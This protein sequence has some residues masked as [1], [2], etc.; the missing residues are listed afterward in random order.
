MTV[1]R[2]PVRSSCTDNAEG[3]WRSGRLEFRTSVG[4]RLERE[5][6][7]RRRHVAVSLG[8]MPHVGQATIEVIADRRDGAS[9]IR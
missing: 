4:L 7:A 9:A 6:E 3:G 1:S 2:A 8:A 5:Q